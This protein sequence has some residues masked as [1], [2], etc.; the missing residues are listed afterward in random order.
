MIYTPKENIVF[1]LQP[2]NSSFAPAT[3]KVLPGQSTSTVTRLT[4]KTQG[5]LEVTCTQ[6][7]PHKGV[8]IL[9]CAAVKM[10]FVFPI[11]LIAIEPIK[12]DLPINIARP[13]RVFLCN[14]SNP[15][16]ELAPPSDVLIQLFSDNGNGNISESTITLTSVKSSQLVRYMGTRLGSDAILANGTYVGGPIKG[17]S[18]R[19]IFFPWWTFLIGLF[20]GFLGSLLRSWLTDDQRK[21]KAFAEAFGCGLVFCL[22]VILFPAGTKL[23]IQEYVQPW[24]IF[25]FA[26]LISLIP[27]GIKK[28]VPVFA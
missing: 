5:P 23:G 6:D 1:H 25:A 4:A 8:T 7:R 13:F 17:N 21:V 22:I 18:A 16:V 14:Q 9:P 20:G 26:F 19:T 11:N 12:G 15:Q 27:E 10:D 24:L 2:G 3:V 28:V